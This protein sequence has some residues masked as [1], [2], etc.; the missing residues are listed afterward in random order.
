[1]SDV[2]RAANTMPEQMGSYSYRR[3]FFDHNGPVSFLVEQLVRAPRVLLPG[4]QGFHL[5]DADGGS[6]ELFEIQFSV[7]KSAH[8]EHRDRRPPVSGLGLSHYQH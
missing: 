8:L 5:V 4:L 1:M 3:K 7:L 6:S 2:Q